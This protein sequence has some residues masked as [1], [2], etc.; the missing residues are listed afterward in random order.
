MAPDPCGERQNCRSVR[1]SATAGRFL[2]QNDDRD[3]EFLQAKVVDFLGF[4][5]LP[6][7][8]HSK[9]GMAVLNRLESLE[10]DED[11]TRRARTISVNLDRA[12]EMAR[13]E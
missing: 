13:G 7:G 5:N 3:P 4:D 6:L 12:L 11:A 9:A 10:S 8:T 2:I 1:T